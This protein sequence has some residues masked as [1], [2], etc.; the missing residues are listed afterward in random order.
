MKKRIMGIVLACFMVLPLATFQVGASS[1]DAK[2][3]SVESLPQKSE[4][5]HLVEMFDIWAGGWLTFED[6][7]PYDYRTISSRKDNIFETIMWLPDEEGWSIYPGEYPYLEYIWDERP[8]P[9]N[10]FLIEFAF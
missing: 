7:F 10:K 1:A 4:L 8:D 6:G 3:I 2:T 5:L 9:Q